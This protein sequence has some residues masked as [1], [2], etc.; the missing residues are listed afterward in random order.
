MSLTDPLVLVCEPGHKTGRP[1]F[2][3]RGRE[4][5]FDQDDYQLRWAT[6]Q[7][8]FEWAEQN[9]SILP[10]H[11]LDDAVKDRANTGFEKWKK[12]PRQASLL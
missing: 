4:T 11:H 3:Q 1:Y 7:E 8:A 9:L 12:E 2:L 6:W 5:F 10:S